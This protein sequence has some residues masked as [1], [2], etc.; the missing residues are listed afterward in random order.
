MG[1]VLGA[2]SVIATIYVLIKN[3][4]IG[5]PAIMIFV[6]FLGPDFIGKE[7]KEILGTIGVIG[8]VLFWIGGIVSIIIFKRKHGYYGLEL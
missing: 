8:F 4:W 1:F 6:G 7:H 3:P 5:I 2:L